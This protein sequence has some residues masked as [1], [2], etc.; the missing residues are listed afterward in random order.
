MVQ[1]RDTR[2]FVKLYLAVALIYT[3]EYKTIRGEPFYC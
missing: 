3:D 1:R 2:T